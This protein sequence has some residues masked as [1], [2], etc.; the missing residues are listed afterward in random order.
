MND[1]SKT[2]NSD[3]DGQ[4]TSSGPSELVIGLVTFVIFLIF[5][6]VWMSFST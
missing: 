4:S 5:M 6:T 2:E 1:E 3:G